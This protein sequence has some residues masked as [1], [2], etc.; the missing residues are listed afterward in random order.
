MKKS[1]SVFLIG[2]LFGVSVTF[3]ASPPIS[4]GQLDG[5]WVRKKYIDSIKST[6]SPF[7]MDPESISISANEHKLNWT[8][9]HEG[10]WRKILRIE[11]VGGAY[12]LIVGPWEVESPK[13]NEILRIPI[14]P[15]IDR[16]GKIVSI[17]FPDNS[18][19]RSTK[20]PFIRLPLSLK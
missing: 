9:Y 5:H 12:F 13:S 19:A 3:A 16:A 20:E 17:E 11:L 8:N 4:L 14:N 10:S 6:R 1:I 7:A 18:L 2:L 15:K